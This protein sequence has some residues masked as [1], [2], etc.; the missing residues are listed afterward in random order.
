MSLQV[1]G[2][3]LKYPLPR[4]KSKRDKCHRLAN[5]QATSSSKVDETLAQA[6]LAKASQVQ[7]DNSLT[8]LQ[9]TGIVVASLAAI[10]IMV[11]V[12]KKVKSK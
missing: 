5:E 4:D 9:I 1:D 12:I 3:F 11:V 6:A 8:P 10:T 2:C 7:P